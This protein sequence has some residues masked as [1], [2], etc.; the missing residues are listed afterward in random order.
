[1]Q[2]KTLLFNRGIWKQNVR[3]V[4]WIGL[5]YFL[6]L[7][8]ALP[9]QLLMIS[10]NEERAYYYNAKG[11]LDHQFMQ[12]F[13]ILLMFVLPVLLAIFLFRYMQV[14]LS[15]DY[16]HSLPIRRETLFHQQVLLGSLILVVPVV[17]TGIIL[18]IL[19]GVLDFSDYFPK[20]E[21]GHW[22]C[23]TIL[24]DLFVFF[25]GVF[26]AVFTGMS[27]LQGA[28]TYILL[29]FPAG[30]MVLTFMNAKY[31]LFGF[32]VDYYLDANS[33]Q[34]IP[35]VRATDMTRNPLTAKEVFV[36][37]LLI[38]IFYALSLVVYKKRHIEA[39]TQAIAFRSLQPVFK[40][41]V[42]F[43]TMLLGGLYF[44]ETQSDFGWLLF[45][46]IIG[47]LIGYLIAEMILQKTWRVF[48][49][50]KGYFYFALVMFVFGMLLQM[51]VTGYEK[52]VPQL[53]D[54][55]RVYF[56]ESV[57]PLTDRY[58]K[59][60]QEDA[61]QRVVYADNEQEFF[62]EDKENIKHIF[63]LH[64]QII[65]EKP[66]TTNSRN[67][68][69][70]VIGYELNNGQ[71]IVRHYEIPFDAYRPLYKPIVESN[72]FKENRYSLLR[73]D[74]PSD[75]DKITVQPDGPTGK[76]AAITDP[77]KIKEFTS[78]VKK[79]LKAETSQ[80]IFDENEGWGYIE[81]LYSDNKLMNMAWKKSYTQVEQ[82]L[83]ENGL[84]E[85]AR[86]MPSDLAYAVAIRNEEGKEIH[87]FIQANE[88]EEKFKDRADA[89][90]IKDKQQLEQCLR[91]A[92]RKEQGAYVI[93]FY[94]MGD[95]Y[96]DFQ[97]FDESSVPAFIKQH[98]TK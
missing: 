78:V 52:K 89:F 7:V 67:T 28:L 3:N 37:I 25:A 18:W 32:A 60:K 77:Q 69:S 26:V 49:R 70:V 63:N 75:I 56:G 5:V 83:K 39:A 54:V 58:Q 73:P 38:I 9:L 36:Y 11:L 29:L 27:V 84:L 34:I 74:S 17:L 16:I 81:F 12:E 15:A 86:V 22:V 14:K 51:D 57:Y 47:S 94:F 24:W 97:V 45:G 41:G 61:A 10:S 85:D 93:A 55:K 31:F 19:Y 23:V 13:Q 79:E 33:E 90:K 66:A 42:T 50:W 91:E 53:A 82:W 88:V 21:I 59:Q 48:D 6:C 40:Y 1:M 95:P 46:L 8:F 30:I 4:G 44:G 64:Q 68:R 65:K 92:K 62:F 96:P 80:Q 35:I 43:C 76:R 20:G 71:K 98:F 72:E 87:H 2:S